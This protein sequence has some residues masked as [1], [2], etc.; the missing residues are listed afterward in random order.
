VA[1]VVLAWRI[2]VKSSDRPEKERSG[3]EETTFQVESES[4]FCITQVLLRGVSAI[5]DALRF[6]LDDGD[7]CCRA[8]RR[9]KIVTAP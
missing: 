1:S 9:M 7:M 5:R 8:R 6:S 4:R 2:V 3:V